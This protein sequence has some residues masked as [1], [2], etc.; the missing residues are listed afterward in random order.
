M[1]SATPH[2]RLPFI[3]PGQAQKHITHN[4]AL[5]T[6]DYL[7]HC[8]VLVTDVTTLPTSPAEGARVLIADQPSAGLANYAQQLAIFENGDWVF[9]APQPG[10]RIFDQSN[11]QSRIY[12]GSIWRVDE[13]EDLNS[14]TGSLANL[15]SL[16]VGT[17][18]NANTV[19]AV[20]G[21]YSL[22]NGTPSHSLAVNR[23]QNTDTASV[24]FQTGFTGR[25]EIGL[26]G[27]DN[28]TIRMSPDGQTWSTASTIDAQ[29]ALSSQSFRSG[30]ITVPADNVTTITPPSNHGILMCTLIW[31]NNP[32]A[33][34]S[35]IMAYD[36]AASPRLVSLATGSSANNLGHLQPT[37]TS[38]PDNELN[39]SVSQNAIH[40][41]NRIN[42]TVQITYFLMA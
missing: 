24:I 41:E 29:G 6:L 40:F 38:G 10:W 2:L 30:K 7:V 19:F 18:A 39:V 32:Q 34:N 21:D 14:Y 16:G 3:Y 17:T 23:G 37:G 11:D 13:A 35:A 15:S 27:D 5:M 12:T 31:G 28:L 22:F 33:D 9:Q 26:T 4:E 20:Q 8:S 36:V 25:A 42:T 1:T